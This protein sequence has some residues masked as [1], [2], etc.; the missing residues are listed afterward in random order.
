MLGVFGITRLTKDR[1]HLYGATVMVVRWCSGGG[2]GSDG[3]SSS[4]TM[5]VATAAY[6]LVNVFVCRHPSFLNILRVLLG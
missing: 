5:A 6:L 3:S 1:S 2:G 4:T